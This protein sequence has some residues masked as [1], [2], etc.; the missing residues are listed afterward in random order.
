MQQTL[1]GCAFCDAEPGTKADKTGAQY[2]D[3]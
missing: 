3:E 1:V 2:E